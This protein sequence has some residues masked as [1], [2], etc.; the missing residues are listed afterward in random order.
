MLDASALRESSCILRLHRIIV[1]GYRQ[2]V[3]SSDMVYGT[4]FHHY[5]KRYEETNELMPSIHEAIEI[6][7]DTPKYTKKNKVFMDNIHLKLTCL[8][9]HNNWSNLDLYD[10]VKSP[11]GVPLTEQKFSVPL[12]IDDEVELL[13]CGTI[14]A[15][16]RHRL[17]GFYA[18]KDYKTTSI[19]DAKKYLNQYRLSTQL[20]F[21][22]YILYKYGEAYPNGLIG[23][24]TCKT[25]GAFIDGIFLASGKGAVFERSEVYFWE[26]S[27][28]KLKEFESGLYRVIDRIVKAVKSPDSELYRE[29]M[30]NSSCEK[31]YGACNFFDACCSD[32]SE[33]EQMILDNNFIKKQYNP[34]QFS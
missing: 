17:E 27:C 12:Y 20:M 32:D 1:D 26:K 15:I 9:Y 19:W 29:G 8:D 4:A 28:K 34:L 33:T 18:V 25:V 23:E 30:L 14:D 3:V 5:R 24:I 16:V 7:T 31:V 6:Y 10:T 11:T 22:V 13:G 2:E 21:Y